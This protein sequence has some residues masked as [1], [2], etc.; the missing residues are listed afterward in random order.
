MCFTTIEEKEI[1]RD[2]WNL[3]GE[4]KIKQKIINTPYISENKKCKM[5]LNGTCKLDFHGKKGLYF[6]A[7]YI[8]KKYFR[9]GEMSHFNEDKMEVYSEELF[10]YLERFTEEYDGRID[11]GYLL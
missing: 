1:V 2:L 6:S 11:S 8:D 4:T 10:E 9:A 7:I 5:Q 3:V